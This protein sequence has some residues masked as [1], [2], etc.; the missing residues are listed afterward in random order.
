M[1]SLVEATFSASRRIS[2]ASRMLG[3]E[4]KS[5]GFSTKI[6]VVKIRIDKANEMVRPIS[7]TQ[8]GIGRIMNR[9]TT[10][11]PIASS[12]VGSVSPKDFEFG[13]S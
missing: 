13:M 2:V 7:M 8:A 3:K 12:A 9:M 6:T 10:I 1:I 11:S 4:E 5:S